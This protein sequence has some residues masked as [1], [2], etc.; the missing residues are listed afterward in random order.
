MAAD[1]AAVRPVPANDG[2]SSSER[3]PQGNSPE[4]VSVKSGDTLW[5]IS[6]RYHVKV[7]HLRTLNQ[8]TDNKIVIGRT[9]R[10]PDHRLTLESGADQGTSTQ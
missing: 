10:L 7:E 1:P 4:R 9:L 6:Q 8:L 5:N 2:T 3:E